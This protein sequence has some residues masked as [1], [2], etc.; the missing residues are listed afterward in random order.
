MLKFFA[1]TLILIFLAEIAIGV[2][3]YFYQ[4]RV[5]AI[6][7]TWLDNSIHNYYGRFK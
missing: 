5:F 1:Y 2:L 3:A 6:L 4:D 7:E